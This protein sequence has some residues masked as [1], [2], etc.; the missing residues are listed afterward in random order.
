M[1]IFVDHS[2]FESQIAIVEDDKLTKIFIDRGDEAGIVG[3]IYLGR[4]GKV[5]PGI[6]SAFVDIG[7][8]KDA[9]LHRSDISTSLDVLDVLNISGNK[10]DIRNLVQDGQKILVQVSKEPI[11]NKGA[12]ISS[13][14]T[15]PG[16]YLVYMPGSKKIGVSRRITDKN[17][18]KRLKSLIHKLRRR[19]NDGFIVRTA[20]RGKDEA[21][22]KTDI[23]YLTSLWDDTVK[24][25][26]ESSPPKSVHKELNLTLKTLRDYLSEDVNNIIVNDKNKKD[27]IIDFVKKIYPR[28]KGQ[29]ELYSRTKPI[30]KHYG[31][32]KQLDECMKSK[33][34]IE[35]GGHIVISQTEALVAIDINSGGSTE[36]SSKLEDTAVNT[37][38]NAIPEIV[39]Q[40]KLR[41][42]GGIIVIDFIDMKQKNNRN[43]VL[44]ALKSELKKDRAQSSIQRISDFGLVEMTRK[45]TKDSLSTIMFKDCHYCDGSGKIKSARTIIHQIRR[46]LMSNSKRFNGKK[47][48]LKAHPDIIRSIKDEKGFIKALQDISNAKIKLKNDPNFHFEQFDFFVN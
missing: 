10:N 41:G 30:F 34:D 42:L 35:P 48:T 14:I 26:K 9:F 13:K 2:S 44:N 37:N 6:Q 23:E 18:R 29:I 4:I 7:L 16:R 12:R 25:A 3:N 1:D 27:E 8:K 5:V 40:L 21:G 33:V 38:L 46:E 47:I 39:R 28:F 11:R 45:R 24:K 19:K 36:D 31:I 22:F 43:R 15:L 17:E 20:G 32:K